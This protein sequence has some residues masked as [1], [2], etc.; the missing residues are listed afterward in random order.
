MTID[1][2]STPGEGLAAAAGGELGCNRKALRLAGMHPI[3]DAAAHANR[4]CRRSSLVSPIAMIQFRPVH[5]RK[6][7]PRLLTCGRNPRLHGET[8]RTV[9]VSFTAAGPGA[10]VQREPRGRL[11]G[12]N[13]S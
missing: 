8:T 11:D 10:I 3:V 9:I 12:K 6:D 13:A 1:A 7:R 2:A 5:Q 4:N